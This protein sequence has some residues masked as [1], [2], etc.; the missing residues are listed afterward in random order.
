MSSRVKKRMPILLVFTVLVLN[1]LFSLQVAAHTLL[2]TQHEPVSESSQGCTWA[3]SA[4]EIIESPV[5]QFTHHVP[6][7][8]L[9]EHLNPSTHTIVPS[10][11]PISRAPPRILR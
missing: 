2:H 6:L 8:K 1:G 5:E 11:L 7:T 3:C 4:G 9:D 10:Y